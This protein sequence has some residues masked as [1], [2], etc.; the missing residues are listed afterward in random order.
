MK[1]KSVLYIFAAMTVLLA[2]AVAPVAA[3]PGGGAQVVKLV[4]K[5][6]ADWSIIKGGAFGSFMYQTDKFV[7]DGHGLVPG[8]EYALISY[9]EPWGTPVLVL[10]TGEA[11]AQG[12]L[13]INKKGPTTLIKNVYAADAPG[14]Y[15]GVTGAKIWLV[16]TSDLTGNLFNAWNPDTYLFETSL[17]I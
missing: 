10:A 7:F 14:D 12:N 17:I 3:A 9:S 16:P 6:S 2:L 11:T 13:I 8:E 1:A 15:Q 5:N 4:A